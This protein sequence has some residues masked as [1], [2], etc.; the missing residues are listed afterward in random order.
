MAKNFADRK[1]KTSKTTKFRSP[2]RLL[3]IGGLKNKS[4]QPNTYFPHT[5]KKIT[6]LS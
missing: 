4:N 6:N 2:S 1:V 5:G 3:P